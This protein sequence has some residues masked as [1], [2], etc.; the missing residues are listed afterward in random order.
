[1]SPE[2]WQQVERLYY[3]ALAQEPDA[4][5]TF[6]ASACAG[7]ESLRREVAAL[8][9]EGERIGSFM[10]PR[11]AG[12]PDAPDAVDAPQPSLIGQTVGHYRIFSLLGKGGMGEVYLGEDTALRRKV[13]LKL[14]PAALTADR[15]RLQRFQQEARHASALNHPNIITIYEFGQTGAAHYLV[16]EYIEGE[17]LRRRLAAGKM[18]LNEA[19]DVAAQVASA[20]AAAHTAGV[21]HRDI[22]PENVMLRPDGL[23]KVL[24]FGLAK[25]TGTRNEEAETVQDNSQSTAPGLLMG[26]VSYMS[27]EQARG[28]KVDH[29]TDIFSLGVVLYEMLAGRRPFEGATASDVIAEILRDEPAPLDQSQ[30][31]SPLELEQTLSRML[32][33]DREARYQSAAELLVELQRIVRNSLEKDGE[34]KYQ[35]TRSLR[36]AGRKWI[37]VAV[38]L[39]LLVFSATALYLLNRI[40]R[41]GQSTNQEIHSL[42]VLPFVSGAADP[43]AESLSDGITE[44]LINNF[45][46]LPQ[47][48]V[49]ARTT[50]FRYKGKD[51]DTR[52]IRG[53]LRVDAIITGKVSLQGD[54]LIVQ[55]DLLNT[56][57]GSQLWGERYDRRLQD[58]LAVQGQIANEIAE[59]LRWRLPGQGQQG[60]AKR[61]TDNIGAYQS[62]LQGRAQAQRRTRDGLLT[63]ISYYQK[64][65]TEDANYT[66]AYAGV[67]DAYTQ[68]VTRAYIAPKEGRRKAQEAASKALSL[69]QNLA[70]AHTAMGQTYIFFTPHDFSTGDRQLRRA[71]ELSPSLPLAHQ[72]LAISLNEQGRLDESLAELLKARELDPLSPTIARNMAWCYVLK[73][74]YGR[75]LEVLRQAKELGPPFILALEVETYIQNGLLTEAL[76]EL[77]KAKRERQDDPVLLY[78]TGVVYAAQGK[79]AAALRIIKELEQASGPSL[80]GAHLI[81]RIYATM[82]EQ[83]LA[84]AWLE[85]G[86]EAGA[87]SIFY[88][89]AP[90]WDTIRHDPRFAALLRRMGVPV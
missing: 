59:K 25:L 83:E 85:R 57:D 63:A 80:S 18:D 75:A 65:I 82:N 64:A 29:R 43:N 14:L 40:N 88:K 46:Q 69:D 26:T 81:A 15:E 39:V 1:M 49:I 48:K 76:A 12:A 54:T 70:E 77:E 31:G 36:L 50:A 35:S 8:L 87:I 53:E 58:I 23:V 37:Y 45:S 71:I 11:G 44:S 56:A 5:T 72:F 22:K 21:T 73:R 6:L 24:D 17:T 3:A 30:P 13:A 42:A 78:G 34:R 27:P 9:A 2:R 61:Y 16:T 33:K 67:T 60:L 90:V 86:L 28:L 84:L 19:L 38:A 62:Y 20:L 79:R 7:D 10:E 66:L 32:A 41:E 55:A 51:I 68:L 74:D 52:V 4:R 89:D 47:L